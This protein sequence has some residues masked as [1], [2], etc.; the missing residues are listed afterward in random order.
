MAGI[1][2]NKVRIMDVAVTEEGRRQMSSGKMKIEFASFTDRHTFY[3]SDT[4]SGSVN[5]IDRLFLEATSLPQDQITAEIDSSGNILSFAGGD[6]EVSAAGEVYRYSGASR[7]TQVTSSAIFSS[8]TASLINQSLQS[9]KNQFIIGSYPDNDVTPY[10]GKDADYLSFDISDTS[11][12]KSPYVPSVDN[13]PPNPFHDTM[14][15]TRHTDYLP[16]TFSDTAGTKKLLTKPGYK[17]PD[18]SGGNSMDKWIDAVR[19]LFQDKPDLENSNTAAAVKDF[20]SHTVQLLESGSP[21]MNIACQ[22]YETARNDTKITKLDMVDTGY[23]SANTGQTYR[24]IYVGK[25]FIDSVGVPCFVRMFSLVFNKM[26]DLN[27]LSDDWAPATDEGLSLG[28]STLG[29]M[30]KLTQHLALEGYS[31]NFDVGLPIDQI[32]DRSGLRED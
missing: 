9:F 25:T 17:Y 24:I 1:L 19:L 13:L 2:N 18:L 31:T 8:L 22:I 27:S 11:P 30:H 10:F 7:L 5:P 15:F 20:P 16:P 14:L 26:K 28:P 6:L 23:W 3:E 32:P 4:A 29:P 21:D 12:I